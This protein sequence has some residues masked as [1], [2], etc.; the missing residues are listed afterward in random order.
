MVPRNITA[1]AVTKVQQFEDAAELITELREV[2]TDCE[3]ETPQ[4]TR[5]QVSVML[6]MGVGVIQRL[7]STMYTYFQ[8]PN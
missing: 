8:A 4:R 5:D 1:E 7:L 3:Y 6:K 2:C